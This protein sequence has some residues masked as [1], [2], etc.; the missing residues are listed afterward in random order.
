M[1]AG[2][3]WQHSVMVHV[4]V[5]H[6]ASGSQVVPPGQAP[7]KPVR[8]IGAGESLLW[9]QSV[10]EQTRLVQRVEGSLGVE[11]LGQGEG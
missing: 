6:A 9:Q 2:A 8:Q 4:P 7:V 1:V 3:D 10:S 11:P 5:G